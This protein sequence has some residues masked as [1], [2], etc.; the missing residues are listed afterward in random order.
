MGVL[1]KS[2]FDKNSTSFIKKEAKKYLKETLEPLRPI[3][4]TD[5]TT[6]K[7]VSE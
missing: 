1:P 2:D 6:N 5:K 3:K 4:D 7:K